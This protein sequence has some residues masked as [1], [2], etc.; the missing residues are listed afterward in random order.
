MIFDTHVHL[1]VSDYTA[2]QDQVFRRARE[3][4]VGL[5]LNVGIDM[6]HSRAAVQFAEK[7]DNVY[8]TIGLHPHDAQNFTE[9]GFNEIKELTKNK[10]VRAIGEV[11]LDYFRNL[12]PRDQQMNVF[13]RF[14]QLANEVHLPLVIHSREAYADIYSTLRKF[15]SRH[16]GVMHCFAGNKHDLEEALALGL[17]ISFAGPVTYKK[18]H[19]LREL[20]AMVPSDRILVETDAPYLPPEPF[21]GKR[22]EP[23]W[24]VETLKKMAEVRKTDFTT[25]SQETTQNGKRLFQI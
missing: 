4:G 13:K 7:F 23:A 3:A 25:I 20:V 14:I 8:A 2:D 24:I 10:K 21:R 19:E 5:F 18:N 22:N 9:A 15:G 12:S 17:Y 1:N 11:G 6:E 16:Q